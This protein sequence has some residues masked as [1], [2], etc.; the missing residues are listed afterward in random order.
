M[1]TGKH[2]YQQDNTSGR[3]EA[4]HQRWSSFLNQWQRALMEDKEVIVAIDANIDFLKW[5]SDILSPS[6]NTHKLSPL[7]NDLFSKI[8]P[9]GVSQMVNTPTRVWP[10]QPQ[11]CLDHLYT[12]RPEK[13][14]EV[15]T[16]YTG[17]SDH[18]VIKVTRFA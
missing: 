17:G 8:F 13:L 10:G 7:I 12:N 15:Y 11:S 4:Q 5:T 1:L 18:K 14:S 9:Y 6:D 2:L 3:L 16:E